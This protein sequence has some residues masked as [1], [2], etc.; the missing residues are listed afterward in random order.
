MNMEMPGEVQMTET[1]DSTFVETPNRQLDGIA[2]PLLQAIL[3]AM[4]ANLGSH[5]SMPSI[6]TLLRQLEKTNPTLGLIAQ[7]L[8]SQQEGQ[9]QARDT[10]AQFPQMIERLEDQMKHL[11]AELEY[12]RERN[13]MLALALGACY[14][15]WGE[16]SHCPACQGKGRPGS[17]LPEKRVFSRWILPAIHAIKA[18]KEAHEN[19]SNIHQKIN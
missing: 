13:D 14:L 10:S 16:D 19:I 2:H 12:L 1:T 5:G 17:I 6:Q 7:H 4:N 3:T 9:Y 8:I 11:Q 18:P 15:C